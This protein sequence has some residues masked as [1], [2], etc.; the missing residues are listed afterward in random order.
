[1]RA[2]GSSEWGRGQKRVQG[3]GG[4]MYLNTKGLSFFL[5]LSPLSSLR[6]RRKDEC[7]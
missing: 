3:V 7:G 4:G 1:M 2:E 6:L 5:L